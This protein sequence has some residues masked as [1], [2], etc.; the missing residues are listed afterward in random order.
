MKKKCYLCDKLTQ[1]GHEPSEEELLAVAN[2]DMGKRI[3]SLFQQQINANVEL[4]K[5]DSEDLRT[6]MK[7]IREILTEKG[8][9][10][11]EEEI[12]EHEKFD[13][14]IV[15]HEN[16]LEKTISNLAEIFNS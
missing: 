8:M 3:M 6:N 9:S 7:F 16:K 1:M 11:S 2:S 15:N 5:D 13:H 12:R 4:Q 10:A 14:T